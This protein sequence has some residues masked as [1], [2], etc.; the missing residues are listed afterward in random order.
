MHQAGHVRFYLDG[1]MGILFPTGKYDPDIHELDLPDNFNTGNG[2]T[3]FLWHQT[4]GMFHGKGGIIWKNQ[5]L[6]YLPSR[7]GYQY[8]LQWTS[9]L[10]CY[11]DQQLD[12]VITLS[13]LAGLL[14]ESIQSDR[15]A[16]HQSVHGTG[17]KGLFL[18]LGLQFRVR[19]ASITIRYL[20]PL[21]HGYSDDEV[22]AEGR[23]QGQIAYLF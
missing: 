22:V 2:A 15:Y 18:H 10:T 8:G 23:L 7:K 11:L 17:G 9:V 19:N 6:D 3:G 21:S 1:G 14:F 20:S 13:P 12:S 5:F 16:N 4:G